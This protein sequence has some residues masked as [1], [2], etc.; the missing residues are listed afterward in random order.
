MTKRQQSDREA[1][2]RTRRDFDE[3]RLEDKAIFLVEATAS[4]LARGIEEASR[5]VADELDDLF[6]RGTRKKQ[7]ERSGPGA[8]EPE[9]A[10]RKASHP[11]PEQ[12]PPSDT[13]EGDT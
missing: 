4:T 11:E 3:M 7:K 9:T 12:K 10:Q 6:R 5:A 8:A 1:Y 13:E 2:E